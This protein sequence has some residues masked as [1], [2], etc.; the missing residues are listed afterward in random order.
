MKLQHDKS[1][2]TGFILRQP[3][4]APA[5]ESRRVPVTVAHVLEHS[6]NET[7]LVY[8]VREAEGLYRKEPTALAI[9][10]DDQPLWMNHPTEDVAA[11]VVTH[12]DQGT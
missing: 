7:T 5:K 6:D 12:P 1:T 10:K 11:I 4:L 2:A 9:R 8:R 3:K